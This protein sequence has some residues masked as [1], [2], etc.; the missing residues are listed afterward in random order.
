MTRRGGRRPR[1]P[2]GQGPFGSVA[3]AACAL[4][5]ALAPPGAGAQARSPTLEIN[6]PA[7]R[8]SVLVDGEVE[9]DYTVCVGS[10]AY[11]TPV[12]AFAIAR[13]VWN[14]WWHPPASPWA[15]G[16]AVTPP[17]PRNPMG[18][19]KL[20]FRDLYYVHGTSDTASLG[21]AASHGC[22]RMSNP[23][24]VALARRVH[25]AGAPDADRAEI[26][27]L[28]ATPH[29]TREIELTHPV[30]LE[31]VYR[32]AEVRRDELLLHPD[33]YGRAREGYETA[34]G[35]ALRQAGHA[36]AAGDPDLVR[37][38]VSLAPRPGEPPVAIPLADLPR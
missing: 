19:V 37:G 15:A 38:L 22:V 18:R 32:I 11:P 10:A 7:Y 8:L 35:E 25:L 20:Y 27:R 3:L 12:G 9:V 4:A 13:I 23:D 34:I 6:L 26:E 30:P 5:T 24:A 29:A 31:I 21:C 16:K 17:G 33:V 2:F 28:A 36:W 1:R 14:P